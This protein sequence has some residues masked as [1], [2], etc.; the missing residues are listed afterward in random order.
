MKKL[1][2]LIFII[3]L[4]SLVLAECYNCDRPARPGLNPACVSQKSDCHP[5]AP[6]ILVDYDCSCGYNEEGHWEFIEHNVCKYNGALPAYNLI[7]IGMQRNKNLCGPC[8]G[9]ATFT[10]EMEYPAH[11]D[12]GSYYVHECV[13]PKE[14]FG[15]DNRLLR[16]KNYYSCFPIADGKTEC[17]QCSHMLFSFSGIHTYF[18]E[19]HSRTFSGSPDVRTLYSPACNPQPHCPIHPECPGDTNGDGGVNLEDLNLISIEWLKTGCGIGNGCCVGADLNN[20]GKVD[21]IDLAIVTGSMG[22]CSDIF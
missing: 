15:P 11:P 14:S 22:I 1:V 20:D 3:L 10:Q 16:G 17:Y 18:T 19:T 21:N 9:V 4:S 12:L 6:I 8:R 5:R 2:L 13:I 7:W